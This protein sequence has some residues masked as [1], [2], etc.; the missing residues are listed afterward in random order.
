MTTKDEKHFE[1]MKTLTGH[2]DAVWG[3]CVNDANDD[4]YTAS[5]D[6]RVGVWDIVTSENKFLMEGHKGKV[7]CVSSGLGSQSSVLVS[8]G[9]DKSIKSWSIET[10][11]CEGSMD[12]AHDGSVVSI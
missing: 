6:G 11:E 2:A 5:W 3:S 10:G 9:E 12:D 8:G 1:L 4:F 7:Y